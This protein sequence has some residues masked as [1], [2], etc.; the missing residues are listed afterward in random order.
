MP[1]KP[2]HRHQH[3]KSVAETRRRKRTQGQ[4]ELWKRS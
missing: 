4:V 2:E 1:I 3:G